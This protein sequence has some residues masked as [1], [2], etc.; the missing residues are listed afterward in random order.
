MSTVLSYKWH[1][2]LLQITPAAEN[3][4]TASTE[5]AV[6][7]DSRQLVTSNLTVFA[8]LEALASRAVFVIVSRSDGRAETL[9]EPAK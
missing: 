5:V 9:L 4:R 8:A 2:S 6:L 7:N 1:L 3:A